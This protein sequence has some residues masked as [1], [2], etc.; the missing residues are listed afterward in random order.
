M[1][2]RTDPKSSP[3]RKP[4]STP[5]NIPRVARR[6]YRL[7]RAVVTPFFLWYYRLRGENLDVLRRIRPPYLLIPNH[8]MTWDPFLISIFVPYPIYFVAADANF[9]TSFGSWWLRR[10]GT[11]AKSKMMD[12]RSTLRAIINLLKGP[13]VVGLFAEGERTWD[14]ATQPILPAT[15]KLVKL[16]KVPVIVPVLKGAFLSLPRHAFTAA[17]GRVVVDFRVALTADE[18]RGLPVDEIRR[19]IE[20]TMHHDDN[21]YAAEVGIPYTGRQAA[22]TMQLALFWCPSC[23][24]VNTMRGEGRHFGCSGCGYSVRYSAYGR[25]RPDDRPR[26]PRLRVGG[27]GAPRS[28]DSGG[29]SHRDPLHRTIGKWAA[30]QREAMVEMIRRRRIEGTTDTIFEDSPVDY[31]TGYRTSRLRS[32][33]R[34]RLSLSDDGIRFHTEE[35]HERL[36]PIGEVRGLNVIYQDQVE[37]YHRRR[38]HVFRF[39]KHDTSGYKYLLVGTLLGSGLPE[40]DGSPP[41]RTP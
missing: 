9:R 36:Y 31:L 16:A 19:R 29:A 37:F 35:G 33:G 7:V 5:P 32:V 13:N 38:L 6:F 34:G 18:A 41:R 8:V 15:A 14:G 28:D 22:Q 4:L 3:R 25:F 1:P 20:A 17:R 24:Q 10:V 21:R 40:T 23:G 26:T 27:T 39:P 30:A 12:D 11:I 2:D